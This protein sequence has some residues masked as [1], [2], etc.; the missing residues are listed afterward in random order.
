MLALQ[1]DL[2]Q[3][4]FRDF[5]FP[6]AEFLEGAKVSLGLFH[7]IN[8]RVV[9]GAVERRKEF[10]ASELLNDD[11]KDDAKEGDED[12][13]EDGRF[14][15]TLTMKEMEL[16]KQ[17][18]NSMIGI[19]LVNE[20]PSSGA[21]NEP[22]YPPAPPPYVDF[23][24]IAQKDPESPEARLV[25]MLGK[26]SLGFAQIEAA[27]RA[28]TLGADKLL[29]DVAYVP[30]STKVKH[31]A[32]ISAQV[33]EIHESDDDSTEKI[34]DDPDHSEDPNASMVDDAFLND[35]VKEPSVVAQLEV[36]YAVDLSFRA[37]MLKGAS[38]GVSSDASS[39]PGSD[40]EASEE[41]EEKTSDAEFVYVG[42]FE[43]YLRGGP[44][45]DGLRWWLTSYRPAFEFG[46]Q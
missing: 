11:E 16:A 38:D 14:L 43:G 3:P 41:F 15:G 26:E 5:G 33:D 31:V 10:F 29:K 44:E 6:P 34:I 12:A 4:L 40:E 1:H 13:P 37:K 20:P 21:D 25:D 45:E 30:G 23:V 8:A 19:E 7:D 24:A 36:L 27:I 46:Y 42:T 2:N 28:A 17:V 32:L 9:D 39:A 35:V 18:S 22:K